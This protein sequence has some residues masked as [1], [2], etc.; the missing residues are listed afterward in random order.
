MDNEHKQ[1]RITVLSGAV[2]LIEIGYNE[3]LE[4]GVFV[5][6]KEGTEISFNDE[7]SFPFAIAAKLYFKKRVLV[8]DIYGFHEATYNSPMIEFVEEAP[9]IMVNLRTSTIVKIEDPHSLLDKNPNV[10]FDDEEG[11]EDCMQEKISK[12]ENDTNTD[13]AN[14]FVAY[15]K[16]ADNGDADAQYELGKMYNSVKPIY[17]TEKAFEYFYKAAEQGHADSQSWVG[18]MFDNG[19]GVEQDSEQALIWYKKAAEQGVIE[20]QINLGIICYNNDGVL[21]SY[22]AAYWFTKAAKQG[23][24]IAQNNLAMI[25]SD[26]ADTI[27]DKRKAAYWFAKSIENGYEGASEKLEDIKFLTRDDLSDWTDIIAISTSG[28]HMVGLRKDGTVAAFGN[29]NNG[30]CEI[31]DWTDIIEVSAGGSHTV[32]LRK[33]GTVVA[34]GHN[35]SGQLDVEDWADITAISAGGFHTVGLKKDGTVVAVGPRDERINVYMMLDIVAVYA[36]ANNTVCLGTDKVYVLGN[37]D[38][39][40]TTIVSKFDDT[41]AIS[42]G[43]G[44]V[45]CLQADGTIEVL[46]SNDYGMFEVNAW[47]DIAAISVG[48]KHTVGLKKDGTVIATGN[49]ENGRLSVNDWT[50]IIAVTAGTELTVGLKR[51]GTVVFTVDPVIDQADKR[52]KEAGSDF[53]SDPNRWKMFT[54]IFEI[55][56]LNDSDDDLKGARYVRT[57]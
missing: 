35:N 3:K 7:N 53:K 45:A 20:A 33:D 31:D 49:E 15:C 56:E 30:Q 51:D 21:D 47:T 19:E 32:G 1:A 4:N 6:Q 28:D 17:N 46:G 5:I 42:A 25:Y 43:V 52:L 9:A 38:G 10:I 41:T 48:Y 54:E 11:F 57:L 23:D 24:E 12:R 50:D 2:Y 39:E 13:L 40:S 16:A 29:N 22:E 37:V 8:A 44:N 55:W 27:Y 14:K 26:W 34:V 18:Y 36:G